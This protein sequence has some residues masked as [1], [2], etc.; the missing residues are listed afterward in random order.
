[1]TESRPETAVAIDAA[2]AALVLAGSG[3]GACDVRSKGPRD[4]VTAADIAVEDKIRGVLSQLPAGPVVGEERGGAA[5]ADG[6][7]Y[8]LVDPICGTR[9]YASGIPLYCTN[10]ALVED[11][12]VTVA[13]SADASTGEIFVAELGRGARVLAADARLTT[14]ESSSVIVIQEG[15]AQGGRRDRAARCC[16]AAISADRFDVRN[17]GSTLPFLYLA[18]GRIAG[19]LEFFA[20]PL[21]TAAGSLIA[22]EAGATIADIDGRP[23]SIGS[24]SVIASASPA[25]HQELL[26]IAAAA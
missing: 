2:R 12:K 21:H 5:P 15:R 7:P 4:V 13:T 6:S 19:Y 20:P 1:M 14:S 18:A 22:A 3:D 25:L 10:I 24:D 17:L 9:N 11:G 26:S 16:A 23:W 8:W